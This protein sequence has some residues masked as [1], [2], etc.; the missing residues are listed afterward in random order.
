MKKVRIEDAVVPVGRNV[1]RITV[2]D[3]IIYFGHVA[4]V[5]AEIKENEQKY[6]KYQIAKIT[7]FPEAKLMVII[8]PKKSGSNDS[9]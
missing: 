1:D 2:G 6:K 8:S 5:L 7:A 3:D 9:D 4:D